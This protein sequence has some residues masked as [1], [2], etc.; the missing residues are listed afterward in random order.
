MRNTLNKDSAVSS[1]IVKLATLVSGSFDTTS[2][3][4][5]HAERIEKILVRVISSRPNRLLNIFSIG[6]AFFLVLSNTSFTQN[7]SHPLIMVIAVI[8][9]IIQSLISIFIYIAY[10]AIR[11]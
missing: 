6:S 9:I 7:W 11:A 4:R 10:F 2:E 8:P 5:S 1:A 3:N